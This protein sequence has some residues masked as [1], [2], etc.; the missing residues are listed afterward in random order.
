MNKWY[1]QETFSPDDSGEDQTRKRFE[2]EALNTSTP[3]VLAGLALDV[4]GWNP[5]EAAKV[6]TKEVDLGWVDL[7]EDD[8]FDFDVHL[9][10]GTTTFTLRRKPFPPRGVFVVVVNDKPVAVR[11]TEEA[12]KWALVRLAEKHKV[13]TEAFS[14]VKIE[15][16]E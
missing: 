9:Q 7:E 12:A 13:P 1:V 3:P 11:K 10:S 8:E 14:V 6:V 5:I 2:F 15:D 4:C 16:V